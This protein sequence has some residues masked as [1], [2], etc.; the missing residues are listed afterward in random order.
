MRWAA[1]LILLVLTAAARAESGN[2]RVHCDATADTSAV[3]AGR[4][5]DVAVHFRIDPGWHIYWTNPGD[6]GLPTTVKLTLPPGFKADPV[7]YPAPAVLP[8]SG[9]LVNYGYESE[10]TLLVRV[11]A[12]PTLPAGPAK[13]TVVADWL[14]CQDR[15]LI[16]HAELPVDLP[17]AATAEPAHTAV[18]AAANGRLV[19][20]SDP[21]HFDALRTIVNGTRW[22]VTVGWTQKPTDVK[23][24]AGR[25]VRGRRDGRDDDPDRVRVHGH[26]ATARPAAGDGRRRADVRRSR[27][28]DRHGRRTQSRPA[29]GRR[30]VGRRGSAASS[31]GESAMRKLLK[32]SAVVAAALA[33]AATQFGAKAEPTVTI[34]SPAPQFTLND[35]NGKPVS[36]SD[37]AGKTVVIEWTNPEC[38]FVQRHY[39]AGTMTTLAKAYADKGVVWLAVN[40]TADA[41]AAADKQFYA[42]QHGTTYP[43]LTDASGAV[44]HLY[45][46]KTTPEMFVVTKAGTVAYAGAIDNDPTGDKGASAT[47]YVR[48]ALD[49][50]LA[51][52]PVE[53]AKTKSYGCGVHYAK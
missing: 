37:Y 17:T 11:T 10:A 27:S 40:S 5:F 41:T 53:T 51:D 49:A 6:S 52:K 8:Q 32:S 16:G 50:V 9:G 3:V 44:G 2:D 38:P 20:P 30:P 15:C 19:R 28:T 7:Q 4:A 21:D 42:Q 23:L 45:D 1:P 22:T 36:L 25:R 48:Q 47:N 24:G 26:A 12:P 29:A 31:E 43:V 35:Q 46:A 14:V 13:I 18:F 39:K 34:G 33:L